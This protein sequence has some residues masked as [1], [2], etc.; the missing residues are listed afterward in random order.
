MEQKKTT[1]S[2]LLIIT[3]KLIY[4]NFTSKFDLIAAK[5]SSVVK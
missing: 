3:L 2:R 5:K 4:A 1:L